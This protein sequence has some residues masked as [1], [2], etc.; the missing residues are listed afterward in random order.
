MTT[1]TVNPVRTLDEIAL[2]HRTD[3]GSDRHD[4]CRVYEQLFEPLRDQAVVIVELG[5]ASGC[6]L[7]MWAEY[8]THPDTVIVGI[9][10]YQ[11]ALNSPPRVTQYVAD[12]TE[13]PA[14][15]SPDI[16]ID[17]ASHLSSKTIGSFQAWFPLL[18]PGGIYAVED[19]HTSYDPAWGGQHEANENPDLAPAANVRGQTAMQF[20]KRLADEVQSR[21]YT[22][23][24]DWCEQPEGGYASE[25]CLQPFAIKPQYWLG[26]DVESVCF[27]P[28]L[29]VVRKKTGQSVQWRFV[30]AG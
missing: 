1:G 25:P 22:A 29:V 20:L 4:F 27:H 13:I 10:R 9:D 26:F 6:S 24:L 28:D 11:G 5:V 17:D 15:L 2:E 8:F 3:K 21:V 14:E 30:P 7:R 12:Q 18:K 19:V 23:D 16:V